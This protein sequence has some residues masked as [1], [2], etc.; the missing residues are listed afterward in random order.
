M[1]VQIAYLSDSQ[2]TPYRNLSVYRDHLQYGRPNSIIL[3]LSGRFLSRPPAVPISR[4]VT[5][6]RQ[7]PNG[8]D[9]VPDIDISRDIIYEE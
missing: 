3:R 8:T 5:A 2:N 1:V 6:T 9:A 4:S 7:V